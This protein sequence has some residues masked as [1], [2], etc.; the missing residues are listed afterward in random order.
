MTEFA[1]DNKKKTTEWKGVNPRWS[2]N[3]SIN[4]GATKVRH[5]PQKVRLSA[6]FFRHFCDEFHYF[7]N[8][9]RCQQSTVK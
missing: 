3:M 8:E 5:F 9:L 2:F 1:L 6:T 7:S 4:F